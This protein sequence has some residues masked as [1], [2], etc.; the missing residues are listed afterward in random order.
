MNTRESGSPLLDPRLLE[1]FIVIGYDDY[2]DLLRDVIHDVPV[3]LRNIRISIEKGNQA[4]IRFLAHSLKGMLSFFGCIAMTARL[5]RLETQERPAP[6]QA[7]RCH[8]ELQSLWEDSLAALMVWE[9]SVPEFSHATRADHPNPF[10][11]G[12]RHLQDPAHAAAPA[13]YCELTETPA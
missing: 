11:S 5:H 10:M 13:K 8:T 6:E 9:K 2:L 3:Y 7:G 12:A 4:D 1:A